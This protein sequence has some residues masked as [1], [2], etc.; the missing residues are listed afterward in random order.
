MDCT[1]PKNETE[2]VADVDAHVA[3]GDSCDSDG[4][5]DEVER[6]KEADDVGSG[7]PILPTV[8]LEDEMLPTVN[9][10]GMGDEEV[11]PMDLGE[12]YAQPLMAAGSEVAA[13][14]DDAVLQEFTPV[15]A[16][17]DTLTASEDVNS[18]LNE[19]EEER[20]ERVATS[21]GTSSVTDSMRS[22]KRRLSSIRK[23]SK[24]KMKRLRR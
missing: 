7:P 21:A 16:P 1:F 4:M 23:H 14:E 2:A 6:A 18:I 11:L 19:T 24:K 10:E 15:T 12:S 5:S 20:V 8:H 3:A 9:N 22:T 17:D 13:G